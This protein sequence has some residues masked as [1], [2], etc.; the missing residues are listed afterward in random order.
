MS[1]I[2]NRILVVDDDLE[3]LDILKRVLVEG[4]YEVE[5]EDQPRKALEKL[6][7]N[8]YSVVLSDIMMPDIDGHDLVKEI[9]KMSKGVQVIL[10]TAYSSI[11]K[12]LDAYEL[13]A[14]DYLLKPLDFDEVLRVV[15]RGNRRYD[16]W[17]LAIQ[18]TLTKEVA[19]IQ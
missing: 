17:F 13:G 11:D 6:L 9:L 5:V 7:S 18:K 1:N 14:S 4:G 15:K 12:V 2:S 10:M 8:Q 19:E 16:R 3:T